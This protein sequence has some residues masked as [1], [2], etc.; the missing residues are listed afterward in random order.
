MKCYC[1]SQKKNAFSGLKKP[2][3][4]S[5]DYI[6]PPRQR[7]ALCSHSFLSCRQDSSIGNAAALWCNN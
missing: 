6:N 2:K 3:V 5:S 1:I 7:E 4:I